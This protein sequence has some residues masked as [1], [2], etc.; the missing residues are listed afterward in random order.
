LVERVGH[1]RGNGWR[2]GAF[3]LRDAVKLG[4]RNARCAGE[5]AERSR[6]FIERFSNGS[7]QTVHVVTKC[8]HNTTRR[9][10][11]RSSHRRT[12]A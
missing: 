1:S 12:A 9:Q 7:R 2:R 4:V 10:E 6:R 5:G 11:R 8:H 3:A